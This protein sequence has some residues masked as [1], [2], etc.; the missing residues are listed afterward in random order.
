MLVKLNS[1]ED[2]GLGSRMMSLWESIMDRMFFFYN[3]H[4]SVQGVTYFVCGE[5]YGGFVR[6]NKVQVGDYPEDDLLDDDE[7]F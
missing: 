6:P 5:K 3:S 4:A 1:N 7:E 2:I